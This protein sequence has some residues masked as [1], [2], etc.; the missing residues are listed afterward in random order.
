MSNRDTCGL[1]LIEALA[2]DR[3]RETQ[4]PCGDGVM[5]C[6]VTVADVPARRTAVIATTTIWQELP[7]LWGQLSGEVW[8]CLRA[9]GIDK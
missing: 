5:D 7:M 8:E 1:E 2:P 9:G 6:K 4:P 3:L